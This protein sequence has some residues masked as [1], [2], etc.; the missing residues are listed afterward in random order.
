MKKQTAEHKSIF[1]WRGRIL[2]VDLLES[3]VRDEELSRAY[4]DGYIG[5]AGINGQ[6]KK[7]LG[8]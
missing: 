1:G 4:M 7:T 5:V 2:R 3:K 8:R 6:H